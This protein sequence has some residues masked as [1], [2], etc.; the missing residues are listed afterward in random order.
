MDRVGAY[1]RRWKRCNRRLHPDSA[2]QRQRQQDKRIEMP[3]AKILT[4]PVL[5][6]LTTPFG[7]SPIIRDFSE[8]Y[9]LDTNR[10]RLEARIGLRHLETDEVIRRQYAEER[11]LLC[12]KAKGH[13]DKDSKRLKVYSLGQQTQ[14]LRLLVR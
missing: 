9:E 5:V 6:V 3:H 7:C 10:Y 12:H 14:E 13:C 1:N 4:M 11:K 8:L 2:S